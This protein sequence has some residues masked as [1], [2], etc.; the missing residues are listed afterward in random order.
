LDERGGLKYV[1]LPGEHMQ[2]DDKDL[3]KLFEI[4]FGPEGRELDDVA[5]F[6]SSLEE[7]KRL[8]SWRWAGYKDGEL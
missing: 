4:Y 8:R 7:E 5:P 1:K 2:F 6:E 3:R